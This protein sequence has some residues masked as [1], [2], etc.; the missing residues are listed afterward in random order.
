MNQAD[1]Q[2]LDEFTDE[3]KRLTACHEDEIQLFKAFVLEIDTEK[4]AKY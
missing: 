3:L 1:Y 2:A 4:E